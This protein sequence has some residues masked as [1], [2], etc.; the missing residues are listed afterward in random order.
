[1]LLIGILE[2]IHIHDVSFLFHLHCGIIVTNPRSPCHYYCLSRMVPLF[3]LKM[4]V[5]NTIINILKVQ[6]RG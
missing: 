1:M 6:Y 4:R 5:E 2:V 3:S